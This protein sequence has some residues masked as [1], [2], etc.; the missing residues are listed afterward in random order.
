LAADWPEIAAGTITK[1]CGGTKSTVKAHVPT[2]AKIEGPTKLKAGAQDA[3]DVFFK[4][5]LVADGKELG[6]EAH[7]D[8]QLGPDCAGV[9]EFDLVLGSQDT[10]G[11]DRM[12]KL[13]NT[14]PGTCTVTLGLQTGSAL[15]ASFKPQTFQAKQTVTIE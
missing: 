4:G 15:E 12:R 14:K 3:R 1:D 13:V 10:G 11:K 9:A 8:W 7:I 5:A 2:G 6:G